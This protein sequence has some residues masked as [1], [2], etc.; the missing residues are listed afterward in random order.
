MSKKFYE[1]LEEDSDDDLFKDIED[2]ESESEEVVSVQPESMY[3]GYVRC[4]KEINQ[5]VI[6]CRGMCHR[7]DLREKDPKATW[8]PPTELDENNPWSFEMLK[9]NDYLD[10]PCLELFE[11]KWESEDRFSPLYRVFLLGAERG[12]Y[13]LCRRLWIYHFTLKHIWAGFQRENLPQ[14]AKYSFNSLNTQIGRE[15]NILKKYQIIPIWPLDYI[16]AN[17]GHDKSGVREMNPDIGKEVK[18]VPVKKRKTPQNTAS[19]ED[20]PPKKERRKLTVE[21]QAAATAKMKET[22]ERNRLKKLEEAIL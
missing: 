2:F 4:V 1:I 18:K 3:D 19:L 15:D 14:L 10:L 8:M 9:Y 7:L 13:G 16:N 20:P 11:D 6:L 5:L 12:L 22:R 17:F 21:E